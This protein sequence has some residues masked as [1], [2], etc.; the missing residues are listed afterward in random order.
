[1]PE[2]IEKPA[3]PLTLD[4]LIHKTIEDEKILKEGIVVNNNLIKPQSEPN[5]FAKMPDWVLKILRRQIQMNNQYEQAWGEAAAAY[6]DMF[7]AIAEIN[8]RFNTN[9]SFESIYTLYRGN[10]A[11]NAIDREDEEE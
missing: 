11:S 5:P 7:D 9:L 1:M 3:L 6:N 10:Y 4:D 8:D 2:V